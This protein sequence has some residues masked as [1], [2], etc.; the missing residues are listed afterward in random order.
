MRL[1]CFTL[2]L[3]TLDALTL[4]HSMARLARRRGVMSMDYANPSAGVK[5]QVGA[6]SILSQLVCRVEFDRVMCVVHTNYQ[7][8]FVRSGPPLEPRKTF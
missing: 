2:L 3:G 6:G 4:P 7:T 1:S 8:C 5:S